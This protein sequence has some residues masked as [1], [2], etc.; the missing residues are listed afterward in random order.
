MEG[1]KGSFKAC[2]LL[3]FQYGIKKAGSIDN[4]RAGLMPLAESNSPNGPNGATTD[5]K[6]LL[7]QHP[8]YQCMSNQAES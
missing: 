6:C 1:W 5:P 3:K 2:S 8:G 4:E 7:R